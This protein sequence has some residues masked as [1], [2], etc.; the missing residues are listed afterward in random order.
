[1]GCRL[2]RLFSLPIGVAPAIFLEEY[3]PKNKIMNVINLNI[4]NLAGVPSIVFGILGLAVFVRALG[5]VVV[6]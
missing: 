5:L 2:D 6:F 1:M 3:A 4:A